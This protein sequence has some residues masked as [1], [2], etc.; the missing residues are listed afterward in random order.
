MN[1]RKKI[2]VSFLSL[3]LIPVISGMIFIYCVSL[4]NITRSSRQVL[5]E[6][7]GRIGEGLGALFNG[8]KDITAS[9]S[10][11]PQ[12]KNKNW[13]ISGPML[14]EI[15]SDVEAIGRFLLIDKDGT[16]WISNNI[17]GNPYFNGKMTSDNSNPASKLTDISSRDYFQFTVLQ[18][19]D[20][21][22]RIFVSDMVL[23]KSTGE[24]QSII[25]ST[26]FYNDGTKG[27][28]GAVLTDNEF[29]TLLNSLITNFKNDF[30][31]ESCLLIIS[32]EGNIISWL[33]YDESKSEL[34]D[35][36]YG[37]KII[38]TTDILP[39]DFND[40]ISFLSNND[41][42]VRNFTFNSEKSVV[43]KFR[44]SGTP[45]SIYINVPEK[46][47]YKTVYILGIVII[48]LIITAAFLLILGALIISSK[49][50]V[51]VER[52]SNSLKEISEGNSDLTLRVNIDGNDEISVLG[53]YFNLF[54]DKFHKII[55][56]INSHSNSMKHI[57]EKLENHSVSINGNIKSIGENLNHLNTKTAEQSSSVEQTF[58]TVEKIAGN[59]SSLHEQIESQSAALNQSSAAVQQMISNIN[60]ITENINKASSSFKE[61]TE[62]SHHGSENLN[63]VK[64]LVSDVSG[65]SS[66]L[67][68]TNAVINSIASQTNLLAMNA[69][70][71][72]AHAGE[73]GKGFSVVADEI[74]KLAEDSSAQSKTIAKELQ[75]IVNSI[76]TIVTATDKA[77]KSFDNVKFQIDSVGRLTEQITLAMT[78]QNE[79]SKQIIEA[80][81][82]IQ[83]VTLNVRESS[84]DINSNSDLIQQEMHTLTKISGDVQRMTKEVS[85]AVENINLSMSD[86]TK[87]SY[88]N[89]NAIENLNQ[90]TKGFKLE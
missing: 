56:N 44:I 4:K 13:K 5:T 48:I 68:E 17:E 87:D 82:S 41:S 14:K 32:D 16:Y 18:N 46:T 34:S 58:S 37:T 24:R 75:S 90:I 65:L 1:L 43:S 59:I 67:L 54:L 20:D 22:K 63:L 69:A 72:A 30:G 50:A 25:G 74:R 21:E 80:L 76:E 35:C 61:L 86:I 11:T 55:F 26:V 47:I 3:A 52:T 33:K 49:I 84:I 73:A 28:L 79:G 81:K 64:K 39:E 89:K 88:E 19:K 6:Y 57:S 10:E 8:I 40:T 66:H 7:S 71:E 42:G 51:P 78:E 23:S 62:T 2:A 15:S 29:Q 31:K 45:F 53:K 38:Q 60:S 85:S 77:S 27:M 83:D 12:I 36:V 70:I 9:I